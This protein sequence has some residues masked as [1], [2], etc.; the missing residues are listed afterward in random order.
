MEPLPDLQVALL[1]P[2]TLAALERDLGALPDLDVR[3]KGGPRSR[4][5]DAPT[6]LSA[7]FG[8]LRDGRVRA[9]QVRYR[10]DGVAWCDTLTGG[11][12]IR[13]VRTQLPTFDG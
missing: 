1:D 6:S 11:D 7:A 10:F 12:G 8:A 4:T 9:V 5:D 3:T 13:L 2:E